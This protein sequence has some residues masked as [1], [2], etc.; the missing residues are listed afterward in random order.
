MPL[1]DVKVASRCPRTFILLD[2]HFLK[3]LF[4]MSAV[5]LLGTARPLSVIDSYGGDLRPFFQVDEHSLVTLRDHYP[6]WLGDEHGDAPWELA[7]GQSNIPNTGIVRRYN[8][9]ITRARIAPDGVERDMF[10]INGQFP[11]PLIEANWGDNIEV[12][13]NNDIVAP[14]EP[15]S[16]HWHGFL[17]RE[18][19]WADGAIGVRNTKQ[20]LPLNMLT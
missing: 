10:A 2:M 12:T 14:G 3:R 5:A 16:M 1:Q 13:V 7:A 9:T 15:T 19:P 17:Q 18:S 4:I 6:Q 11:G 20:L 8:F